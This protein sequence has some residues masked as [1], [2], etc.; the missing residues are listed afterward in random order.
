MSDA[1]RRMKQKRDK[2]EMFVD[3]L[4]EVIDLWFSVVEEYEKDPKFR[5]EVEKLK[6]IMEEINRRVEKKME[7]KDRERREGNSSVGS[8]KGGKQKMIKSKDEMDMEYVDYVEYLRLTLTSKNLK[9]KE[10]ID[11]LKQIWC[12]QRR[13]RLEIKDFEETEKEEKKIVAEVAEKGG[14]K[15]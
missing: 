3:E 12:D 7:V 10:L 6:P 15:K 1:E 5:R 14:R 11:E 8:E 9:E 2:K 13:I 4:K